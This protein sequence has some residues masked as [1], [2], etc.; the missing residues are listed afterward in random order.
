MSDGEPNEGQS[1]SSGLISAIN[2]YNQDITLFTY[3]LGYGA[4]KSI[5]KDLACAFNGMMFHISD[6][7]SSDSSLA[8]VMKS[9]YTYIAEGVSVESPSWTEPYEDA[10]GLGKMVTVSMAV[11]Y[12]ESSIRTILGVIGLDVSLPKLESFNLTEE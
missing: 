4:S 10:F 3:A 12:E 11:Y 5:L 9:Y 2:E 7:A 1:S 8:T 6:S